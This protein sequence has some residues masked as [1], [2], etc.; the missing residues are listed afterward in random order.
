MTNDEL[1]AAFRYGDTSPEAIRH[2]LILAR[3]S[4]GLLAKDIASAIGIAKQTYHSQEANGSVAVKTGRNFYR[5]HHIDFNFLF[6][7]DFGRLDVE[8]VEG[9]IDALGAADG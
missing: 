3:K 6:Y 9:L 4:T 7:G 2:R 1:E 8:T 5:K